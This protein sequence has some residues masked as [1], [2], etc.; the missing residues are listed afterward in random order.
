MGHYFLTKYK[1]SP[2]LWRYQQSF[3]RRESQ[4][5]FNFLSFISGFLA[6]LFIKLKWLVVRS[7]LDRKKES[8]LSRGG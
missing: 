2:S 8:H 3:Y 6:I 1:S 7:L 5:L 4:G